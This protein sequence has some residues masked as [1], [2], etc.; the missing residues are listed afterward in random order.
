MSPP[1]DGDGDVVGAIKPVGEGVVE[2]LTDEE[3][4]APDPPPHA[5]INTRP[6]PTATHL[7][8]SQ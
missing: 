1:G 5:A 6:A 8:I 2:E 3:G 4:V 7:F